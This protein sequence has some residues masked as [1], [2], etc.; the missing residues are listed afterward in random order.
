MIKQ[1]GKTEQQCLEAEME[2]R[3]WK[4]CPLWYCVKTL[5]NMTT[6]KMQSEIVRDEKTKQLIAI[7]DT[8][9]PGQSTTHTT[10]D[11]VKPQSRWHWQP[12]RQIQ[13]TFSIICFTYSLPPPGGSFF[14]GNRIGS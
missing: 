13:Q 3:S 4:E 14:V 1:M 10:E 6:G 8:E 9:K 7:Q 12:Y 11:T 5:F 2:Y